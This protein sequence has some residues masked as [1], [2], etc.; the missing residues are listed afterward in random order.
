METISILDPV[1]PENHSPH[2]EPC[3][4][5]D[6]LQG[7]DF[8]ADPSVFLQETFSKL[9]MNIMVALLANCFSELQIGLENEASYL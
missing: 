3:Y 8:V 1:N 4:L 5:N 6:P 9:Q 2:E 7:R